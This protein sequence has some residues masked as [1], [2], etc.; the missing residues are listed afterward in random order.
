MQATDHTCMDADVRGR[1][2]QRLC[3]WVIR[4][5]D[6]VITTFIIQHLYFIVMLII[7]QTL[8]FMLL[9]LVGALCYFFRGLLAQ[10]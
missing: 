8:G 1:P 2:N 5:G 7:Y 4:A 9:F 10:V 6:Y 3:G